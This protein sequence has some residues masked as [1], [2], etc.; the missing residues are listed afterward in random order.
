MK[1]RNIIITTILVSFLISC[2]NNAKK[3]EQLLKPVECLEIS[4]KNRQPRYSQ[5]ISLVEVDGGPWTDKGSFYALFFDTNK[6]EFAFNP[7]C[8]Y[9]FPSKIIDN[10]IIFYWAL[11]PNCTFDRGLERKYPNI[12]NPKIGEPFGKI[13][14]LSDTTFMIEYYYKDWVK[15]MNEDEYKTIDTLFPSYF[16]RIYW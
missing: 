12:K 7:S 15:K 5:N 14:M 9:C 6:V 16:Y 10:E 2:T 4:L 13:K 8:G 1:I 11:N 3:T